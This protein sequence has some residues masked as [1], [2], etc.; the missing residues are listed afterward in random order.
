MLD[1]W[2]KRSSHT[3]FPWKLFNK[4]K[5]RKVAPFLT[6]LNK[7]IKM[8]QIITMNR[9]LV[10]KNKTKSFKQVGVLYSNYCRGLWYT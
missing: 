3:N 8:V 10:S 6:N 2:K 4:E 1:G 9:Q 7:K 5:K